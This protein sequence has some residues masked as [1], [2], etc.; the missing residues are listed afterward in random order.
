MIPLKRA[1]LWNVANRIAKL[2]QFSKNVNQYYSTIRKDGWVSTDPI[3]TDESRTARAHINR[4]LSEIHEIII[5]AE[6]RTRVT[7]LKVGA[8]LVKGV[9]VD[10]ISDMFILSNYG[11]DYDL[12]ND[13]IQGAI[14]NLHRYK[15]RSAY[16][17]LEPLS[18]RERHQKEA[19]IPG[20]SL[21]D[22]LPK[23]P[24]SHVNVADILYFVSRGQTPI[25]S[26]GEA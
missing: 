17:S 5:A 26:L 9:T 20:T 18:E 14:G 23:S 12:V 11:I 7:P 24:R 8:M 25:N 19:M 22:H 10:L 13:C 15:L 3:E 21:S 16:A 1:L 6:V 2:E 4:T